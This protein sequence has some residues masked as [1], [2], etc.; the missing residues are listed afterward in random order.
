MKME[1]LQAQVP[2]PKTVG[3]YKKIV[4]E[5]DVKDVHAVDEMDMHR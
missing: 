4:F 3:N 1:F 2:H 5:F